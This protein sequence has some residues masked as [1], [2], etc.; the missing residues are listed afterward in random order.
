[1]EVQ[2]VRFAHEEPDAGGSCGERTLMWV[3]DLA[4]LRVR[5]PRSEPDCPVR[6]SSS[7][8]VDPFRRLGV[9]HGPDRMGGPDHPVEERSAQAR[10][11]ARHP[12]RHRVAPAVSLDQ[13]REVAH[14]L[15]EGLRSAQLELPV[16]SR[17]PG[18]T[19]PAGAPL[20]DAP[21]S[22]RPTPRAPRRPRT[23]SA[24]HAIGA[25]LTKR[26]GGGNS[27]LRDPCECSIEIHLQLPPASWSSGLRPEGTT[28]VPTF[29]ATG[30]PGAT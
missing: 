14:P 15:R 27:R 1:M 5:L 18:R 22:S 9:G 29:E 25:W 2:D 17:S 6:E 21:P 19:P 3:S 24:S 20:A 28:A 26:A 11:E 16:R 4:A 23:S 10:H 30:A 13:L 12:Q 8:L 7:Q